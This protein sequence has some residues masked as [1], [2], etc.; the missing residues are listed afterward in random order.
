MTKNQIGDLSL[1]DDKFGL[2]FQI[3]S[4]EGNAR[5]GLSEGSISWGGFFGTTF[6]ADPREKIIALLFI[7]QWPLRHSELGDK[8]K[9]SVYQALL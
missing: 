6:W 1:G 3:T 5:L 7:Q 2:G 9:V 8:F 4:S